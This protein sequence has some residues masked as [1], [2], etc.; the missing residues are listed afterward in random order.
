MNTECNLCH[1]SGDQKN[2]YLGSSNGTS[3]NLGVGCVGC[4][5]REEDAGN[6]NISPG[7]GAGLRQHHTNSQIADCGNCHR[8]AIPANYTPVD[9]DVF[10]LYYG[11]VDTLASAPCNPDGSEGINENW[12]IGDL[13]GLDNDGD[14]IYDMLDVVCLPEPGANALLAAGLGALLALG[15]RR[16]S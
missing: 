13:A 2:P 5:G 6:D 12:S 7:R 3:D 8:D 10:P 9:E 4:H 11:T 16:A 1:T 14:R 15:R